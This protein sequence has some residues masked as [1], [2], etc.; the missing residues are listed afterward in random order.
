[1]MWHDMLRM[2]D[3]SRWKGCIAFGDDRTRGILAELPGDI[4]IA[5]WQYA[6][7]PENNPDHEFP[8]ANHLKDSGFDVVLCPWMEDTGIFQAGA[9][10]EK[11][12]LFGLLQTTWNTVYQKDFVRMFTAG[13]FAAWCGKIEPIRFNDAVHVAFA[14]NLR[15][16]H[17]DM[18]ITRY[19]DTG[20]TNN[21]I[22]VPDF[23]S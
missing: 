17:R 23:Q 8:T 5:D 2:E 7:A 19:L 6:G 9:Q 18:N 4:I 14:R 20:H 1:M 10:V 13:A 21:Q 16:V 3:D 11:R 12:K 22:L 15:H